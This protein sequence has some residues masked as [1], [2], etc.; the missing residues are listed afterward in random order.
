MQGTVLSRIAIVIVQS[1]YQ[2]W[3]VNDIIRSLLKLKH[4]KL[5]QQVINGARLPT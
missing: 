2:L 5:R 3:K 1:S 4:K